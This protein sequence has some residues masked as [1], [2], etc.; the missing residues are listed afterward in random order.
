M[1]DGRWY[2]ANIIFLLGS[3]V[4]EVPGSIVVSYYDN[5][6]VFSTN[7][8]LISEW[9]AM[10]GFSVSCREFFCV[11]PSLGMAWRLCVEGMPGYSDL[12]VYLNIE[13]VI[14]LVQ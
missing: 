14:G 9:F 4:R 8:N 12:Y 11:Q 2:L 5:D 1:D 3:P 6:W 13:V 10:T 7:S